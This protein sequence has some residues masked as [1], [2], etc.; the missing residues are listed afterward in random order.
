MPGERPIGGGA[1]MCL[2]Q[3]EGA[4][5]GRIIERLTYANVMSTFALCLALTGS[6]VAAGVPGMITSR[7]IMDN[8]IQSRDVKNGDLLAADLSVDARR[9]VTARTSR[10]PIAGY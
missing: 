9:L 5:M 8:T 3:A 4:N 7:R 2:V 6:A 1:G 10:G